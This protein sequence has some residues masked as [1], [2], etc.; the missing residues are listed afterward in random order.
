VLALKHACASSTLIKIRI[1]VK[2]GKHRCSFRETLSPPLGT[3]KEGTGNPQGE[4][5]IGKRIQG[6]ADHLGHR[7]H[8]LRAVYRMP[9][10]LSRKRRVWQE[11]KECRRRGVRYIHIRFCPVCSKTACPK[12]FFPKKRNCDV[13]HSSS[14]SIFRLKLILLHSSKALTAV[15]GTISAGLEGNLGLTTAVVTCYGEHLTGSVAVLC[16]ALCSTALR[17]AAG[18]VLET[19]LGEESLLG[20]RENKF[21][22]AVS[23]SKCFVL[24]HGKRPPAIGKKCF[25]SPILMPGITSMVYGIWV[26]R[27]QGGESLAK[28]AANEANYSIL[29]TICTAKKQKGLKRSGIQSFP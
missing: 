9:I 19:L 2:S 12:G 18:L 26:A 20:S 23:T 17:A 6:C 11:R 8:L 25:L 14:S 22:S 1:G 29:V 10:R 27:Y 7:K 28:R 13:S 16:S 5:K 24:V 4:L 3:D 15:D 21:A